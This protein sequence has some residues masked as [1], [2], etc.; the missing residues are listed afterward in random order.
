M[1]LKFHNQE[2]ICAEK[3]LKVSLRMPGL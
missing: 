1:H 3:T 2:I